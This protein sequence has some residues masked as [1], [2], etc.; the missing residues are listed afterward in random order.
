MNVSQ[1][2][3]ANSTKLKFAQD[4][5][6]D[7]SL[8][9]QNMLLRV[10]RTSGCDYRYALQALRRRENSAAYS[11]GQHRNI[12]RA[13]TLLLKQ[14]QA[15]RAASGA[16]PLK[17]LYVDIVRGEMIFREWDFV[18]E[19]RPAV[20]YGAGHIDAQKMTWMGEYVL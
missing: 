11:I 2:T 3:S 9:V 19:D 4:P 5:F 13:R 16:D 10:I 8:R 14:G 18:T 20:T 7:S 17:N 1:S 15:F 12:K 6:V